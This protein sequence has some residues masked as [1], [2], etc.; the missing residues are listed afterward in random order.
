MYFAACGKGEDMS[1]CEHKFVY[2]GLQYAHGA[3]PRA[4]TG[5]VNR[6]YAHVFFCEKCCVRRAERIEE[7]QPQ[8]SYEKVRDGA[9]M[10]DPKLIAPAWDRVYG[11]V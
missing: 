9:I 10:G 4:G 6:Y 1:S 11:Y 8:N 3:N 7:Q 5:A 2:M